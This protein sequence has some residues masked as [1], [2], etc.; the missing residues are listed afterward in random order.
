MPCLTNGSSETTEVS[1]E[2]EISPISKKEPTKQ[3]TK[4]AKLLSS[5]VKTCCIPSGAKE[6]R[7]KKGTGKVNDVSKN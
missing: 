5:V 6:I 3:P 4:F 1:E 2:N 7:Y